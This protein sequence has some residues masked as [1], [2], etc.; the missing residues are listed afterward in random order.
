MT[1]LGHHVYD[2]VSRLVDGS[3]YNVERM[4][5]TSAV[6][7]S[8]SRVGTDESHNSATVCRHLPSSTSA[9]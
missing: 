2:C 8:P 6:D 3:Q 1:F 7:R 5:R 9:V 4:L